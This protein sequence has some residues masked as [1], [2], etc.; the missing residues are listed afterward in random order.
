V[1]TERLYE[2]LALSRYLNYSRA[3]RE[4]FM[5]QSSLSRHVAEMEKELGV[6]LLE[7]STHGVRLTDAGKLLAQF[8]QRALEKYS[9]ALSRLRVAGL[10]VSGK[11]SIACADSSVYG[12]FLSFMRQF[13]AKYGGI[14][15]SV[16]VLS[17]GGAEEELL[18]RYDFVFSAFRDPGVL[19][20]VHGHHFMF[21]HHVE[22]E[23]LADNTLLVP[24]A[25]KPN[26]SYAALGALAK[27]LTGGRVNV[28]NTPTL[29]S[30]LLMVSLGQG[31]AIVPQHMSY[32][33][34]EN[35][36]TLN[37]STK[38]CV[39]DI[40]LYRNTGRDNPAARLFYEEFEHYIRTSLLMDRPEL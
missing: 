21:Q 10:D 6:T 3:A 17:A 39:F 11:V 2:F 28:V 16:D 1:T 35:T 31:L 13:N 30:A 12:H 4:L 18:G 38:G 25:D 36:V 24:Y 7:R 15:Y 33:G 22:L 9:S 34:V 26:C 23:E 19:S 5:T 37:I 32:G 8:S 20:I 27:K 40:Y 29:E 14:E